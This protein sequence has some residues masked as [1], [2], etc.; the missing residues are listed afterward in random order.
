MVEA[1]A[2]ERQVY[3]PGTEVWKNIW[4]SECFN[5]GQTGEVAAPLEQIPVFV[6]VSSMYADLFDEA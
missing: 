6:K 3:L 4:T 5:G 1:G 2:R